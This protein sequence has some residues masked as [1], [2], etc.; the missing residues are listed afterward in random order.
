MPGGMLSVSTD[1]AVNSFNHVFVVGQAM[2]ASTA[3]WIIRKSTDGG[4]TW[5]NI[6]S[7]Q[8]VNNKAAKANKIYINSSNEIYVAGNSVDS[9]N[10]K[11]GILR[12]STD[13]GTT[14]V[15]IDNY[16]LLSTIKDTDTID[17]MLDSLGNIFT[18]SQAKDATNYSHW[19]TR[20]SSNGGTS[21]TII[22]DYVSI[23]STKTHIPNTVTN[24]FTKQICIGG[25]RSVDS[26]T[27]NEG[28]V[29]IL[30]PE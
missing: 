1:I 22:D 14:W 26:N 17:V 13:N 7:Y 16:Q 4:S 30:S 29:R 2:N 11:H 12:K 8:L 9:S 5:N 3:F 27:I 6:N 21:W 18:I 15:D 25:A 23:D 24:C 10:I 19:I 28:V 20:K